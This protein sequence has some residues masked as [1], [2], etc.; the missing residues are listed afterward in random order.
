MKI[1]TVIL[2]YLIHIKRVR[3]VQLGGSLIGGLIEGYNEKP[4]FLAGGINIT[5]IKEAMKLNPYC[6]DIS[7]GVEEN[8]EKSL[9]KIKEVVYGCKIW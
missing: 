9:E 4:F 3:E 8:G 6:I 1:R 7:S 5:N 2:Y